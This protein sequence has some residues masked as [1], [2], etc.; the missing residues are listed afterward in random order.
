MNTET[1]KTNWRSMPK[2]VKV[3]DYKNIISHKYANQYDEY[4]FRVLMGEPYKYSTVLE[5]ML[6]YLERRSDEWVP[7][8]D[9]RFEA[10]QALYHDIVVASGLK[11]LENLVNVGSQWN[12]E[13][14]TMEFKWYKPHEGDVL[15]QEA[16]DNF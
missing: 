11:R 13:K 8:T 5:F 9:I 6:D 15:A 4:A 14:R 1:S 10:R 3:G 12:K 2:H 7:L 16:V